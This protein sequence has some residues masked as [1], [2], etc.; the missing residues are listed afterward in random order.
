MPRATKI[1]LALL[2]LTVVVFIWSGIGPRE[3]FTWI[4]EVFPVIV[5]WAVLIPTYNRFRLSTLAYVLLAIHGVILMV[6]GH[7]TY[8]EV[9]LFNWIRDVTGS[10]RNS[11]DG[12]GHFAQGFIPAIVAREILLRLTPLRRGGWLFYIIV[13]ICL[14]ISAVYELIEWAVAIMSGSSAESFLGTQGDVWDTQ[15]DM[16]LAMIGAIVALVT[17]SRPHDRSMDRIEMK[18]A[19]SPAGFVN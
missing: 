2:L 11:Y 19:G 17:L 3:R 18:P 5:G 14:A 10:A 15:K 7:Y 1:H 16:A 9:P 8:A 6:G 4:L 12:V 13:S